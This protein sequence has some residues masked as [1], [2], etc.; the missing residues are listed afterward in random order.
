MSVNTRFVDFLHQKYSSLPRMET[1]DRLICSSPL[2]I[3]PQVFEKIRSEITAYSNLRDWTVKHKK[4]SF[5]EK[6]LI[7]PPNFAV[8]NSFDFHVDMNDEIHLIE[9]NTNAA[10]MALGLNLYE[11]FD[12]KNLVRFNES[13]LVEMFRQELQ[14]SGASNDCI[15]IMDEKPEEQR[16]YFEFL[17][18]KEIFKSHGLN[19]EIVDATN[20]DAVRKIPTGSFVYNRYTDFYLNES[21]SNLIKERYNNREIFLSPHP[22]EYFQ[23]ADK[24]RFL[25]W[26]AQLEV[27]HPSSLL[28]AYDLDVEPA[29]KIWPLR[30][31]YFFKPKSSFGSKGVFKGASVSKKVFDR[32]F[33]NH[34]I[35]QKL[36]L[37]AEIDIAVEIVKEGHPV[38]EIQK[39]K[40]DLRCYTYREEL[41]MIIGRVYQGQTT[42]LRTEGGGFTIVELEK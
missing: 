6:K 4:H 33:G 1:S 16:M 32:F 40:Y 15:F 27:P 31:N 10:F 28:P 17:V 12:R 36:A 42:N 34:F 25:D 5:E 13:A 24:E 29:E 23:I 18:F 30:K 8:C 2:L 37:P 14:L 39:M 19:C 26:T 9:I 22:W 3:K 11:F 38:L 20:E 21:K 41:Q 35:A 7:V